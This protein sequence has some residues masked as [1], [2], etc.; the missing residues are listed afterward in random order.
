MKRNQIYLIILYHKREY[1]K[2]LKKETYEINIYFSYG[3]I[4]PD[5]SFHNLQTSK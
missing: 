1:Y 5:L 4:H 2:K 3:P